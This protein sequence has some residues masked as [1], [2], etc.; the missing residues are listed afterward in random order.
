MS[1][2]AAS[3]RRSTGTGASSLGVVLGA[4][5]ADAAPGAELDAASSYLGLRDADHG[6]ASVGYWIARPYRGRGHAGDALRTLVR[7]A[8]TLPGIHRLELYVEPWNVAS[9]RTASGAG[10]VREGLLRSW[11]TVGDERRD[12]D[13]YALVRPQ[14]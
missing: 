7:W 4:A 3:W 9:A 12:M 13:M 6:R 8:V 11:Q 14:A 5:L 1:T 2:D 10:F